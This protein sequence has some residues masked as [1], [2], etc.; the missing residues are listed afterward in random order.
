[1]LVRFAVQNFLSFKDS[2]EFSMAAGKIVR[3]SNHLIVH[4]NQ[5]I[6]KGAFLFGANAG[7]KSNFIRAIDFARNIIVKGLD[8]VNCDKKYFRIEEDYRTKPGVF[9]FDFISNGHSYSYGFAISYLD[10]SI[11]E[12]WLYQTDEKEL[13]VFFRH[14]S[15]DG[16]TT[17]V[18]TD[19]CFDNEEQKQRFRVFSESIGNPKMRKILFLTDVDIRSP[20]EPE[21]Q[22]FRDVLN[23]FRYLMIIFPFSRSGSVY[24]LLDNTAE[25]GQFSKLLNYFDT[26][27]E[28][29]S[30]KESNFDQLFCEIPDKSRE[31]L[32]LNIA[33]HLQNAGHKGKTVMRFDDELVEVQYRDGNLYANAIVSN[34]GNDKDLFD[35]ADESDGTRRLFDLIPVYQAAMEN[36]VILIDEIDRSLHSK[37]TQEFIRY[38]YDLT[39]GVATQIIAT[40]QDLSIMDLD[41]LRQ[42]EI[43]FIERQADHS[44]K[45]Y[46]LNKYKARFDKK[47]EKDYLLGRYGATP[48]FRQFSLMESEEEGELNE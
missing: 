38:F 13:C 19:L 17:I 25:R 42:D 5:R 9:Q 28:A 43:W 18:E 12:E 40:S 30:K 23:W 6:L 33:K 21:Y 36:R 34:H 48:I 15:E 14:P 16:R 24:Q 11:E 4:N 10:E 29:V 41:F 45:L 32:K 3:H 35:Y 2:T 20:D 22:A 8:A 1:M 46:S 27:I 26:G 37:V 7:G 31:N 44:S 47:V 39:D